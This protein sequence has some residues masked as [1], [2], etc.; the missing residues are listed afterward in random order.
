VGCLAIRGA[1]VRTIRAAAARPENES[2]LG[3]LAPRL[4]ELVRVA[5]DGRVPRR[6]PTGAA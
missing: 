5:L 4:D 6:D 3:T 1:V 2:S